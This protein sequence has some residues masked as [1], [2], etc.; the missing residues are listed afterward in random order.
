MLRKGGCRQVIPWCRSGPSI[1]GLMVI[2]A[3]VAGWG[4]GDRSKECSVGTRWTTGFFP[5][6]LSRAGP[7]PPKVQEGQSL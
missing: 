3:Y 6:F 5:S 2:V 4:L 1:Q 7:L